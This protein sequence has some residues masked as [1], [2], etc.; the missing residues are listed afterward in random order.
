MKEQV[1][2]NTEDIGNS[3]KEQ[4][5]V[6]V[7]AKKAATEVRTHTERIIKEMKTEVITRVSCRI[8]S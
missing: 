7:E 5:K 2:K 3:K 6:I 4:K 1:D 8:G